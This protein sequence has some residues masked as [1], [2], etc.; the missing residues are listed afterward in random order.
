[1][2]IKKYKEN[3]NEI[4]N[5]QITVLIQHIKRNLDSFSLEESNSTDI[6]LWLRLIRHEN[7][8]QNTLDIIETLTYIKSVLNEENH[9]TK[10]RKIFK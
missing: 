4:P 10:F 9:L 8:Q 5:K 7:I 3:I 1:M 6:L 2:N